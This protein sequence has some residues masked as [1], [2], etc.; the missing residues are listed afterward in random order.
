[1]T[2][3]LYKTT[4]GVYSIDIDQVEWR[5]WRNLYDDIVDDQ[6]RHATFA[7]DYQPRKEEQFPRK[8]LLCVSRLTLLYWID[9]CVAVAAGAAVGSPDLNDG[10]S[11][12]CIFHN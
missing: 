5:R 6:S 10:T 12:M 7:T 1:M 2:L 9:F 3:F 11:F 8:K 4:D